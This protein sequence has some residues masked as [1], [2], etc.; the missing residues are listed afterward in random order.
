MEHIHKQIDYIMFPTKGPQV[1]RLKRIHGLNGLITRN[2]RSNFQ[3]DRHGDIIV[4][5]LE[6]TVGSS[7]D[8]AIAEAYEIVSRCIPRPVPVQAEFE[9]NG[10]VVQIRQDSNPQDVR[11]EWHR[12]SRG[13][14]DGPVG[15]YPTPGLTDEELAND[16]RIEE[17][18]QRKSDER[19]AQWVADRMAKIKYTG[20]PAPNK[21]FRYAPAYGVDLIRPDHFDHLPE[22]T[23]LVCFT[24]GPRKRKGIDYIDDDTRGGFL[25]YGFPTQSED[26]LVYEG[27]YRTE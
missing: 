26:G 15:P 16:Q 25:A 13:Y 8:N 14:I 1:N 7:I 3:L 4:V 5:K 11:R 20:P 24:G 23:E 9:F 6:A 21:V 2:F 22:G 27:P 19:Q 18:N 10:V 12:A 17:E